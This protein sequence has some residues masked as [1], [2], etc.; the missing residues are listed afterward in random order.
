MR[1]VILLSHGSVLCG[2]EQ[3]LLEIAERLRRATG[4]TIEA[5]FLNYTAPHFIDAVDR[6]VDAG[7]AGIT[8]LPYFLIA[9]KFVTHDL[10]RLIADAVAK[11]P[12]LEF[13]VAEPIRYHQSLADAVLDCARHAKPPAEWRHADE[14]TTRFCRNDQRCP[15]H[16]T[17]DCPQSAASDV[18]AAR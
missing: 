8:V 14:Q 7:A 18:Q 2:A 12:Q 9:G 15:L 4:D 11:Y 1:A 6:C 13:Q 16:G 5:A 17:P 10:P 3:N